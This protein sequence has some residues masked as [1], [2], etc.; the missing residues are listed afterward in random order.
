MSPKDIRQALVNFLAERFDLVLIEGSSPDDDTHLYDEGYID[1]LDSIVLL[2]FLEKTFSLS[3]DTQ[4]LMDHPFN[5][6][7]EI[8]SFIAERSPA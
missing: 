1:S 7:N 3:I 5:T 8:V 4:D 6:I 2:N